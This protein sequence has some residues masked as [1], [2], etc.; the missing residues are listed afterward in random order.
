M[1]NKFGQFHDNNLITGG[2]FNLSFNRKLESLG[3]DP[4]LKT[5]AMCNSLKLL[6]NT[7]DLCDIW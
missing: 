6:K 2:N 7:F 1:S 3:E 4:T 5:F